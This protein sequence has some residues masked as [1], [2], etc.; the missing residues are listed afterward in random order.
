MTAMFA[1]VTTQYVPLAVSNG[2]HSEMCVFVF[3][4]VSLHHLQ[5]SKTHSIAEFHS[6]LSLRIKAGRC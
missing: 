3:L 6:H 4:L 2:L 1:T 5:L